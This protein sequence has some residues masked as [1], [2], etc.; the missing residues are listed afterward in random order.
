MFKRNAFTLVEM[1]LVVALIA[2]LISMLM[3]GLSSARSSARTAVCMTQ[4]KQIH[5]A[6][7]TYQNSNMGKYHPR[8]NWGRWYDNITTKTPI[9][10]SHANAYWGVAYADASG[11]EGLRALF[12]C[13]E[14]KTSDQNTGSSNAALGYTD[15]K[16][17]D[18]NVHCTYGFNGLDL[19]YASS[20]GVLP[21]PFFNYAVSGRPGRT[22]KYLKNPSQIVMF[23]DAFEHML[24]GNGDMPWSFTQWGTVQNREY[25]RHNMNQVS[26]IVWA[27]GHIDTVTTKFAWTASMYAG[28]P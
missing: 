22:Q 28:Q 26:N 7:V 8:R 2:L 17:E 14:A 23:Q 18:G 5:S 10:A 12:Q 1:L 11:R 27:D 3:P 19:P 21:S 15:G 9:A 4:Q 25:F 13:P 20:Q 6:V 16:F 24:D